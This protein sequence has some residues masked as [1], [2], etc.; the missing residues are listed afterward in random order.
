[1]DSLLSFY[2]DLEGWVDDVEHVQHRRGEASAGQLRRKGN[3]G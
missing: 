2:A 1:M 3:Q